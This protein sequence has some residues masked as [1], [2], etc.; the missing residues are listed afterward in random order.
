MNINFMLAPGAEHG[1]LVDDIKDQAETSGHTF[2]VTRG[3]FLPP[4][5]VNVFSEGVPEAAAEHAARLK[6]RGYRLVVLISEMPTLVTAE[7]LVWNYWTSESWIERAEGFIRAAP[8]YAAAWCYVPGA[9]EIIR[10]FIPVA[11]DVDLAWGKRFDAARTMPEPQHDFCFYGRP[12][13]RRERVLEDFVRRGHSVDVIPFTTSMA[14]RDARV[15]LS[16]VVLDVK[17]H[18]WWPLASCQR[19]LTAI[20][21]GRPVVAEDRPA[22]T[23]RGWDGIA[24][25]APEGKFYAT[26]VDVLANWRGEHALQERALRA[27]PGTIGKALAIL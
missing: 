21:L 19:Y 22:Q 13:R 7:G 25:F 10:R 4:P 26:A 6:A 3:V 23:R 18:D 27:K 17:Q 15:P 8:H 11:A 1:E 16:R 5:A 14:E 12:T 9:A 20:S 2:S 24:V